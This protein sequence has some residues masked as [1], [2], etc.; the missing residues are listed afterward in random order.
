M[1]FV[2]KP[3]GL[4]KKP[5]IDDFFQAEM[6]DRA[7]DMAGRLLEYRFNL[8]NFSKSFLPSFTGIS[9]GNDRFFVFETGMVRILLES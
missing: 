4:S 5:E 1:K 9:V 7:V 2:T 3:H 6:S 8:H